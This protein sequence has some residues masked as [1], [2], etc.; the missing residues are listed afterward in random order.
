MLTWQLVIWVIG[1]LGET[2][3]WVVARVTEVWGTV[4]SVAG[5]LAHA[6]LGVQILVAV[7]YI[8]VGVLFVLHAKP[9]PAGRLSWYDRVAIAAL[10]LPALAF[11]LG[12]GLAMMTY[13][14]GAMIAFYAGAFGLVFLPCEAIVRG[15][16]FLVR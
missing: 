7:L 1:F 16:L 4:V 14:V 6:G 8:A 15:V 9:V 5:Y 2:H 12:S 13:T 10:W 3:G 11:V